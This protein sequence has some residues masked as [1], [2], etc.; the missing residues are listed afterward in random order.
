MNII[1]LGANGFVGKNLTSVFNNAK[2]PFISISRIDGVDLRDKQQT[3]D[4]FKKN[5]PDIIINCA[6]HVGSLNYVTIQAADVIIDNT[7]M[8][9]N[10]YE[11]VA[12]VNKY[13]LIINPIANCAYPAVDEIFEEDD[14]WKGPVHPSVLAYGGAKRLLLLVAKSFEMQ[15]N[16]N[17]INL[18]VPNMYGPFDS[19]DPHKAHALNALI[20]R[21]VK[22]NESKNFDIKLWG[23]G[24]AIR[25]WLYAED[26]GRII[27]HIIQNSQMIGLSEPVNIGQNFGLSIKELVKL[28]QKHFPNQFS[29]AWDFSMPDGAPKK[30][31]SDTK[32]RKIFNNFEFTE[33]NKGI[34][35]TI[36]YYTDCYPY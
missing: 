20:S 30:V 19:T 14:L 28:I 11:A 32:F 8:I 12:E 4:A 1:L 18:I 34:K 23:T 33:L 16:I 29:I 35:K 10:L 26:F 31:M 24:V 21:F 5:K 15:F 25:E 27:L 13:C 7:K 17:T 22:G 3:I 36:K 9:L 2:L 6:A